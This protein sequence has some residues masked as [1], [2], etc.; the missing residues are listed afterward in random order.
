VAAEFTDEEDDA[1]DFPGAAAHRSVG[2]ELARAFE[3]SLK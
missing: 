2:V 3:E 1:L